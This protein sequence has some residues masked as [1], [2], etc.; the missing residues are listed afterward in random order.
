MGAIDNLNSNISSLQS[1][2]TAIE[3]KVD[4]LIAAGTPT[5]PPDNEAAIQAAADAV[6]V[7]TAGLNAKAV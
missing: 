4:A 7:V 5:P 2:A 6:A 3:A 1:A